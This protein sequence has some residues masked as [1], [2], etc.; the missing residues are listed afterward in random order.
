M[1]EQDPRNE[2]LVSWSAGSSRRLIAILY[3]DIEGYSRLMDKDDEDTLRRLR[4]LRHELIDPAIEE[5]GGKVVQTG[6]DSLLVAFDSVEGAVRCAAKVQQQV[7]VKDGDQQPDRR[8]RFRIGINVG[9]VIPDG[10]DMH[11][12]SVNIAARLEKVAP[13]GGICVSRSVR[14]QVH[15]RLGLDFEPMGELALKNIARPVEAFVLRLDSTIK[16]TAANG[17]PEEPALPAPP[18]GPKIAVLPVYNLSNDPEQE[19]FADGMVEEITTSALPA[20]PK[21][22]VLPFSSLSNDPEQEYF[23]DGMVEEITTALAKVRWLF[24][25]AR[26]SSFTYKGKAA[27][28]REVGRELGVRFVVE[29]SVRRSAD[30][31]RITAQL[32][33]TSSG[34]HIWA[35]RFDGVLGNVLELQDRVAHEV[36]GRL[37]PELMRREIARVNRRQVQSLSAYD[38]YLRALGRFH[39]VKEAAVCEAITL[40]RQALG[41]DPA[42][43]AAAALLCECRVLSA[44]LEW[45]IVSAEELAETMGLAKLAIGLGK[46][47]P[48]TLCWSSIALL[49]FGREREH[50]V[51][52]AAVDHALALNPSAALGWETKGWL[53]CCQ[54]RNDDAI[55]AFGHALQ[56]SPLDPLRG[57]SKSGIARARLQA[58]DFEKALEFASEASSD[59]PLLP[60][61][62]QIKAAACAHLGRLEEAREWLAQVLLRKPGLTISRWRGATTSTGVGR[63]RI[64]AGLRMAGLPEG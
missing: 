21:I 35:E 33:D 18:P 38:L 62:V 24:V 7:P 42:Y 11:G 50:A 57:F 55:K 14:D 32:I 23:A 51:V 9:D 25:V 12:P 16:V 49:A 4:S 17:V 29:G 53:A 28:V 64:E 44:A 63:D 58:G 34:N 52:K 20:G 5:N 30:E 39:E 37:Q 41:L 36:A 15:D 61:P 27:D 2:L 31:V 47:D 46:D 56:L 8:I 26:N 3:A 54:D 1:S 59:L 48:D 13:V 22:A 10:T 6:G 43:A 60:G 40:L 19:Y 45:P